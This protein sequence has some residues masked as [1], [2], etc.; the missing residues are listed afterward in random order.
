M[1]NQKSVLSFL[2]IAFGISWILFSLPLLFQNDSAV[3][4]LALQGFFALAMWGP[5]IA[6][7][8][9][10]LLIDKQPFQTLGLNKLGPK[11]FY[12]WAWFLPTVLTL[13]TL[14]ITL[15]IG[16]GQL[17]T[18]FSLLRESLAS[19]PESAGLPPAEILIAIQIAFAIILAPWIN[20]LFALGEELGWRAYLLPKLMS[21]GQ[22][23]AILI[24]GAIW[25]VWHA[26]TTILFGYNFPLH[27]I[28]G[29]LVMTI[30]TTLLGIIFSWLYLNTNSPW[31][32]AL[33][34]GALN[35]SAGIGF[36]FLK[37]GFDTALGGSP[38]GLAGWIAMGFFISWLVFTK[39]LPL[40][41]SP[42]EEILD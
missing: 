32:V 27:P 6:A 35:A 14:G 38:L 41:V 40:V 23:R 31:V 26:P 28:L 36:L 7:I 24:S 25:G 8:V 15:L 5:G 9:T 20:L 21:L 19:V 2:A 1:I 3:F 10:T 34:H 11:R 39:R 16:T 12:L 42:P 33:A 30:G 17:D 18:D 4:P 13:I 22:G 29:V 37:P